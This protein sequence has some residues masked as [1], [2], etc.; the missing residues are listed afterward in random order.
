MVALLLLLLTH[1]AAATADDAVSQSSPAG[2]SQSSQSDQ[3]DPPIGSEQSPVLRGP[4]SG[5][6]SRNSAQQGTPGK[7]PNALLP[8]DTIP[9][10]VDQ[11]TNPVDLADLKKGTSG[12]F[13][14]L[15]TELTANKPCDN[16]I[17]V[18]VY[19][20]NQGQK[21]IIIDG[22][23]AQA[24]LDSAA[25]KAISEEQAMKQSG[26][27]FTKQQKQLLGLVALGTLGLAEPILQD[28]FSTSKT[29][30][31]VSYGVN[32][33]RRRLEDRRLAKRI[34]LPGEDT[35]G[36][37][38]FPGNKISFD[39][40]TIPILS[41]PQEQAVGTLEITGIT[42][43]QGAAT[44]KTKEEKKQNPPKAAPRTVKE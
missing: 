42:Q 17:G 12:K 14:S 4:L 25:G 8:T 18:K 3:G 22:E 33:T 30:F 11:Y 19:I 35:E 28:H 2:S 26:S 7:D 20:Q 21:P 23:H 40:V 38:F 27:T 44:G 31:P 16:C 5:A 15:V 1:S 37:I 39:K 13:V 34:I 29:D 10:G 9:L 6:A 41:Y 32:E 36:I 24:A 43:N